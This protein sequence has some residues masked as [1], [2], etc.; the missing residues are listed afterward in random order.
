MLN[1]INSLSV[2]NIN[3]NQL[4]IRFGTYETKTGRNVSPLK[5]RNKLLAAKEVVT[6]FF[7]NIT[8]NQLVYA[9]PKTNNKNYGRRFEP[10][11]KRY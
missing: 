5:T 2:I 7:L 6:F 10:K 8:V 9:F 3:G 1:N 4:M 11:I